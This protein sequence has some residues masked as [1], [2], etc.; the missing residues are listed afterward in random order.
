MPQGNKEKKPMVSTVKTRSS[1]QT[2]VARHMS[3]VFNYMMGG[4]ALSGLVAFLTTSSPALMNIAMKG[5]FVFMIVWFLSG[6]FMQKVVFSLQPAAALG[7]FAA[8]SA[9]TGF[10]L[11]PL[12]LAYTGASVVTAF[13]TASVMFGGASLYGYVTQKSLS[14][15]GN[16][17]MMGAWG[18]V[19][20]IVVNLV[21]S[22]FGNPISGLSFVISLVAVP[23]FA[24]MTAWETNQIKETF[25]RYGSDEL[26][27]SRLA[28]L[29]ATSLY[30]N[31][32]TIFVHLLNIMGQRR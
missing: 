26:T 15:W 17:L 20:A 18:L 2:A 3:Q 28:I 30:L 32:V 13:L 1:G 5:G 22:L 25:N 10:M 29:S 9:L 23:L 21:F 6:M 8:F 19:A 12:V 16:F 14:G 27:R 11:S 24:G 4:V 7:V 31:F